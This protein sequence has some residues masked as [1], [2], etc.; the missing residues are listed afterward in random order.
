M[1]KLILI[2]I[3]LSTSTAFAQQEKEFTLKLK[4][5]QVQLLGEALGLMP[6]GKVAPFM[7]ELQ[8]QI[9]AQNVETPVAPPA[10][11]IP[12]PA[13]GPEKK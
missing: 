8:Q 5:S 1:K 2:A 12:A 10:V 11:S 9:N 4:G 6:Y 13:P 3:L 7:G